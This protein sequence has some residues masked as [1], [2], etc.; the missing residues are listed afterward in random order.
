MPARS[1]YE[2]EYLITGQPMHE[3]NTPY[4]SSLSFKVKIKLDCD[5]VEIV[6]PAGK[7]QFTISVP[8]GAPEMPNTATVLSDDLYNWQRST[9]NYPLHG[10]Y[11][12]PNPYSCTLEQ[13]LC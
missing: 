4:P 1:G 7:L 6:E 10:A 12:N 2:G 11:V 8:P 5:E 13:K 3:S 9:A